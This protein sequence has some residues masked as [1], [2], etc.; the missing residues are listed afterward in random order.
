[1][2][3]DPESILTRQ[4]DAMKYTLR[5][6]VGLSPAQ[7]EAKLDQLQALSMELGVLQQ[8]RLAGAGF[9][10]KPALSDLRGG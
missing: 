7:L 6:A 3:H 10:Y 2:N 5:R 9:G 8:A 1:M 4:V